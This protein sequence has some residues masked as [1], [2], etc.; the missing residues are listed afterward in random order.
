MLIFWTGHSMDRFARSQKKNILSASCFPS[1]QPIKDILCDIYGSAQETNFQVFEK[2]FA[3]R[4]KEI[5]LLQEY[6]D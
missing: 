1:P 4:K 2:A 6:V 5:F 3:G